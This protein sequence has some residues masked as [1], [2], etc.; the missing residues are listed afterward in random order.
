MIP[1]GHTGGCYDLLPLS[2][3]DHLLSHEGHGNNLNRLSMTTEQLH[4]VQRVSC[5]VF[6]SLFSL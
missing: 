5:V 2:I 3:Y 6:Y 1:G 4:R